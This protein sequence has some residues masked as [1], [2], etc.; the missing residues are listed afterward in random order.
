MPM[1]RVYLYPI[2]AVAIDN[3]EA[4]S[5][6]AA[7]EKAEK[8]AELSRRF[9]DDGASNRVAG[10][11]K[12]RTPC[13]IEYAEFSNALDGAFVQEW[14]EDT[15]EPIREVEFDAAGGVLSDTAAR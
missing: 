5:P 6:E 10:V 4:D 14:V 1:Y 2:V 15:L 11:P 12:D 3:V 13:L 9:N 7:V 8:A